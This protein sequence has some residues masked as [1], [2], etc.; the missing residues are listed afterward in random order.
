MAGLPAVEEDRE[1]VAE[2]HLYWLDRFHAHN[3]LA[4]R[5]SQG[6]LQPPGW[7]EQQHGGQLPAAGLEVVAVSLG[8]HK[9]KGVPGDLELMQC[10]CVPSG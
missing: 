7:S 2:R 6:Q 1:R 3:V 10:R 4:S 8:R 9:L 5:F